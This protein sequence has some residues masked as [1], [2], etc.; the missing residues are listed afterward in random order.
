MGVSFLKTPLV[1]RLLNLTEEALKKFIDSHIE[2]I[3]EVGNYIVDGGGKRLRPLLLLL[4]ADGGGTEK[5]TL[6]NKVL[7]LAVGIEYIHT[8]S[9]LH[10]DVVDEAPTRRGKPSAHTL[11]GNAVSVLTGDYMYAT[12]L[13]LFS[14]Y[15]NPKMIEVVSRAVRQMAEGQV[16][17]LKKVG[18]LIDEKTYFE[19]IDGK[20]AV[21]FAASSAVGALASPNLRED[22]TDFWKFGLHLGRAFQLID[23]ALDYEGSQ[24]Q[25]G[26]PTG[27]DLLEGKTTYPLLAVLDRLDPQRVKKILLQASQKEIEDTVK[28]VRE[29]GGVAKTKE[30]ARE[31]L[32]L[33][34][35]ILNNSNL[36]GEVKEILNQLVDFIVERTY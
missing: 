28:L 7:P 36:K 15:G 31:E 19:I 35:E 17:E 13:Y 32:S 30:R 11:F 27:Q 8:A 22:Y 29:L 24:E 6:E 20:T 10:D 34:R 9:L 12:A 2:A 4:I 1:E 14:L 18:E 5:T 23:D 16:L 21:L 25:L 26:K 3:L 33:A